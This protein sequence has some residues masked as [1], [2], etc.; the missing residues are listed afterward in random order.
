MSMVFDEYGRPFII[1]REQQ[2]QARIKG[3]DAQKVRVLSPTMRARVH[4]PR[5][6]SLL[7]W[8]L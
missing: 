7:S 2:Q 4:P 3:L 5:H 8:S 6:A 1:L